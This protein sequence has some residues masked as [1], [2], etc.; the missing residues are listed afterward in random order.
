M[1]VDL[2][3]APKQKRPI[4]GPVACT[5]GEAEQ[6]ERAARARELVRDSL[7]DSVLT[8]EGAA[9]RFRSEAESALKELIAAES[10]CCPFLRFDLRRKDGALSLTVEGPE[11]A[12]PIILALF[13]LP[14]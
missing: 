7:I 13:G 2:E 8:E 10:R 3:L 14:A 1:S 5:L 12:R 6:A 4:E 9:L 11:E